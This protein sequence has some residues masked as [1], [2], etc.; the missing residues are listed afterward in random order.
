MHKEYNTKNYYTEI[1]I[2]KHPIDLFNWSKIHIFM[3]HLFVFVPPLSKE[4]L[5]KT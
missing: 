4:R 1:E 5:R 3:N 2:K